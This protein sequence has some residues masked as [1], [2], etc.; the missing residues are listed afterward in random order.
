[1]SRKPSRKGTVGQKERFKDARHDPYRARRKWPDPTRC[2]DCHAVFTEGRWTWEEASAP[3]REVKCPACRRIADRVPAGEVTLEGDFYAAHR[4][5]IMN[6][7]RSVEARESEERP[8][9]RI[10]SLSTNERE[11]TVRT[12]GIH[13]ARRLG[14]AL[15]R[16]YRGALEV[17]YGDA[18]HS[19]RVH[20]RRED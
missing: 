14:D 12:T 16:A 18:D 19:V 6:L 13:L 10:M 20:W 15:A 9:E 3:V 11:A 1:M 17:Q 8:L 4:G 2:P 7:L 5:E